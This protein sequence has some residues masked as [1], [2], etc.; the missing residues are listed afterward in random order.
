MYHKYTDDRHTLDLLS[1]MGALLS[2]T[3]ATFLSLAP[4]QMSFSSAPRPLA[5][6]RLSLGG[7]VFAWEREPHL[8]RDIQTP[9]HLSSLNSTTG[10]ITMYA[11]S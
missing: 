10:K 3:T 1:M 9:A 4:L 6:S 2:L 8:E 7:V 11:L 5:S